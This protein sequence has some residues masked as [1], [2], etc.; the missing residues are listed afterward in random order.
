MF[1]NRARSGVIFFIPLLTQLRNERENRSLV[2]IT[3]YYYDIPDPVLCQYP[4]HNFKIDWH[5]MFTQKL[6]DSVPNPPHPSAKGQ[7]MDQQ[8]RRR[9]RTLWTALHWIIQ[10]R[11]RIA[12]AMV[13]VLIG[14]GLANNVSADVGPKPRM[15]FTLDY[16]ME[17]HPAIVA[18]TLLECSDPACVDAEP[19]PE[20]GP[21]GITCTADTCS[22]IAYG[23][24]PYHRLVLTFSDGIVRESPPFTKQR[25]VAHYRVTVRER[26]L[27]IR[28]TWG[29][30]NSPLWLLAGSVGLLCLSAVVGASLLVASIALIVT[31]QQGALT[32]PRARPWIVAV[33]GLGTP[34]VALGGLVSL[35]LPATVALEAIVALAY[36]RLRARQPLVALTASLVANLVTLPVLWMVFWG[37][38]LPDTLPTIIWLGE[39]L[40]WA[41]ETV[42]LRLLLKPCTWREA[43]LLSLALNGASAIA[44]LVLPF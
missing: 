34:L 11:Y 42:L 15:E 27:E 1:C 37:L 25:F 14:L 20:L 6:V 36:A 2:T 43:G 8:S 38:D 22:S 24:R 19:L 44:G 4:C 29:L 30:P 17:E 28:E 13:L 32:T 33:W 31:A 3:Y 26:D 39:A 18:A 40:V 23:Y 10:R 35:A 16:A 7:A 41:V 12:L 9:C 5:L 21:Q